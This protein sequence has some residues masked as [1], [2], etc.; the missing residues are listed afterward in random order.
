MCVSLCAGVWDDVD[1][2]EC[3]SFAARLLVPSYLEEYVRKM[4]KSPSSH[5]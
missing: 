5:I 4:P 3:V 2:V 1:S